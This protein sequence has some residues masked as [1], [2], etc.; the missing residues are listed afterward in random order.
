MATPRLT[1]EQIAQVSGLVAQYIATQCERYASR[2]IPL[3]VPQRALMDGFFSR[4]LIDGTRL[5]VLQGERVANP[6]F[7]PR[8][9][10]LGFNNLP[11]QSAQWQLLRSV[12][13]WSRT[14]RSRMDCC[15]TNS[16]TW[17]SIGNLAFRDFPGFTCADF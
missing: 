10:S 13:L 5:F 9:R 17:N 16:F 2:A 12:M 6:G 8:L 11:D 3:S 14:S 15:F 1:Q 7:Y 4:L